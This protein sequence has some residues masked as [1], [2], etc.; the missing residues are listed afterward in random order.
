M[1]DLT[2]TN[3]AV[4]PGTSVTI[5]LSEMPLI[6]GEVREFEFCLTEALRLIF[7]TAAGT[8]KVSLIIGTSDPMPLLTRL[9]NIFYADRLILCRKYIIAYGNNGLPAAIPHFINFNT[10]KCATAYNPANIPPTT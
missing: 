2:I 7:D 10:P 8:E 9:G 5:T 1:R 4:V 3:I 6:N